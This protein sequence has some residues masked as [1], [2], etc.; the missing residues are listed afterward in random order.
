M[1]P[2]KS[3]LPDCPMLGH[4]SALPLVALKTEFLVWALVA[5]RVRR[6]PFEPPKPAP[7]S[8]QR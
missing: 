7:L 3:E 5:E 6:Q 2:G 4:G 8:V 1:F